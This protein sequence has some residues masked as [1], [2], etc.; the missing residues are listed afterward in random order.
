MLTKNWLG[1]TTVIRACEDKNQKQKGVPNETR[2]TTDNFFSAYRGFLMLITAKYDISVGTK[3]WYAEGVHVAVREFEALGVAIREG[4]V[5][6]V[7]IITDLDYMGAPDGSYVEYFGE[8]RCFT[9]RSDAL[10][11]LHNEAVGMEEKQNTAKTP[12]RKNGKST[13]V[14][15]MLVAQDAT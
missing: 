15:E 12:P 2:K 3:L 10:L 7:A 8:N 11:F 14:G 4:A 9:T 13:T 5:C 1:I 6:Y